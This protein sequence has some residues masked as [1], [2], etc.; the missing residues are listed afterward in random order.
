VACAICDKGFEVHRYRVT[1]GARFY[2]SPEHKALGRRRTVQLVCA[3]C[4][5]KFD[6]TLS[7]VANGRRYCSWAC[8]GGMAT[9]TCQGCG[10]VMVVP[11]SRAKRGQK[12]CSMAC[13]ERTWREV[14]PTLRCQRQ[15][16]RKVFV[17]P[18]SRAGAR[19]CS[20][21]CNGAAKRRD[22][23]RHQCRACKRKFSRPARRHPKFCSYATRNKGREPRPATREPDR[24]ARILE[25]KGQCVKA[26]AIQKALVAENPTWWMSPAAIR[27]VISRAH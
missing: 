24:N 2:C 14:R 13:Y 20:L 25:L 17:V 12:Y 6:S 3:G 7:A 19:F 21:Q 22:H 27:Q 23:R 18:P 11:A 16:C 4:G 10:E 8:Y 26:P 1:V 15:Q 9:I 5:K